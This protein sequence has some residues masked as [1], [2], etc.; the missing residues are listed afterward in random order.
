MRLKETI[1]LTLIDARQGG[2]L[3]DEIKGKGFDLDEGMVLKIGG[4]FYHGADCMV[5][6]AS[7]S[8][9]SSVLNRLNARVFKSPSVARVVYPVLR[10]G[11]NATLRLLGRSKIA[12]EPG[13]Q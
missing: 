7:M 1:D 5:V 6:L 12:T 8:G 9:E 4:R 13:L 11:R 3:V 10:T 2:P